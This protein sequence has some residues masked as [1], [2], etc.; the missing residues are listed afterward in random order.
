MASQIRYDALVSPSSEMRKMMVAPDSNS[1]SAPDRKKLVVKVATMHPKKV[2]QVR[3][4]LQKEE[5]SSREK[6]RPGGK[7]EENKNKGVDR[8]EEKQE[9][10]A[11][12]TKK[13]RRDLPREHQRRQ[14]LQRQCHWK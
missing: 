10:R 11:R 5:A 3:V 6:S 7:G 1:P 9:A 4:L 14:T 8:K 2:R 13:K 12:E